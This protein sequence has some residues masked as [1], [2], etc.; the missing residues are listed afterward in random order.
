MDRTVKAALDYSDYT[1]WYDTLH[2]YGS[3][4]VDNN[5]SPVADP[6]Q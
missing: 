1:F 3:S 4:W 2:Q 5:Y 6:T